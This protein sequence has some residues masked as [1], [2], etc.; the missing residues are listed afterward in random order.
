MAHRGQE[1]GFHARQLLQLLVALGEVGQQLRPRRLRGGCS[2]AVRLLFLADTSHED[3]QGD[4]EQAFEQCRRR[5]AGLRVHSGDEDEVRRAE[6]C[7]DCELDGRVVQREE[8][9]EQ[10][11]ER[12]GA[13]HAQPELHLQR[14]GDGEATDGGDPVQE[15]GDALP[16]QQHERSGER[17]QHHR[18]EDA[19]DGSHLPQG[20]EGK[21]ETEHHRDCGQRL[22]DCRKADRGERRQREQHADHHRRDQSGRCG[23]LGVAVQ[24][25]E[26]DDGQPDKGIDAP[27]EPF[28][29]QWGVHLGTPACG[30]TDLPLPLGPPRLQAREGS[31]RISA[32]GW[33]CPG[34]HQR[35][36]TATYLRLS[37]V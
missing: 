31:P 7:A 23:E 14:E 6:R 18:R 26:P 22:R 2:G 17:D 29:L 25:D 28:R 37:G 12:E 33:G 36:S 4:K 27:A 30:R 10:Q 21:P 24:A 1:L 19:E 34:W 16:R 35:Q 20:I 11:H 9:E 5:V 32:G 3:S 13:N 15:S 8:H